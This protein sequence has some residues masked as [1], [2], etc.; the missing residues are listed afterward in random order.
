VDAKIPENFPRGF[1]F[2]TEH[3]FGAGI[4]QCFDFLPSRCRIDILIPQQTP[5]R[6]PAE[7]GVL[8]GPGKSPCGGVLA[9]RLI[10]KIPFF[11]MSFLSGLVTWWAQTGAGA[12]ASFAEVPLWR[13]TANA[14][15][16]YAAYMG[17]MFWPADLSPFYPPRGEI[18]P[19]HV[20]AAGLLLAAVTAVALRFG[21]RRPWLPAGWFRYLGTLVPVIGL[22]QAG[23]QSMADHHTYI[24]LVGL[25]LMVA[26]N[27][28]DP[29]GFG[30]PRR[31]RWRLQCFQ[32]LPSRARSRQAD[33]TRSRTGTTRSRRIA[34]PFVSILN[35]PRPFPDGAL[36]ATARKISPEPLSISTRSLMRAGIDCKAL[37]QGAA[38][39]RTYLRN[40]LRELPE[41]PGVS[42]SCFFS[43]AFEPPALSS[44]V[45]Q[46]AVGGHWRN[47][48][49]WTE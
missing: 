21:R 15:L 13:R 5:A 45:R 23:A 8:H 30:Q 4:Q 49:Y 40:L 26:W 6:L 10:E 47:N 7:G 14:V 37:Q 46:V 39:V 18:S 35:S 38:G 29:A 24:P 32:R 3:I 17:K 33:G 25:F 19:G 22:A 31:C 16:S 34:K 12:V 2:Q 20:L 41:M 43:A 28:P 48:W 9:R 11:V 44:S 27:I 36:P 42:L 1:S